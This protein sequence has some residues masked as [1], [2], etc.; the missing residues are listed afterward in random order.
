MQR[1]DVHRILS[2]DRHFDVV[3]GIERVT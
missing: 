3:P 1:H 2:F